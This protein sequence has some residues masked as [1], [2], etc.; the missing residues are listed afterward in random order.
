MGVRHHEE[1]HREL[2]PLALVDGGRPG[3]VDV[4]GVLGRVDDLVSGVL[5]ADGSH[6]LLLAALHLADP[7]DL[8]DLAV[9]DL[10]LV[11]IPHLHHPVPHGEEPVAQA[12]GAPILGRGIERGLQ[13]LVELGDA[14][15]AL[16]HAGEDLHVAGDVDPPLRKVAGDHS[17]KV[18]GDPVRPVCV[19][20][21]EPV[22]GLGRDRRQS[23]RV[24]VVRGGHDAVAVL[25]AV[26][27]GEAADGH[28]SR[29][30]QVAQ[31]L[32]GPD[33]REL[34]HV[35][36]DRDRGARSHRLEEGGGEPG[37]HHRELVDDQV[38]LLQGA[39]LV[40]REAAR[41]RLP[42]KHAVE[43]RGLGARDVRR[44]LGRTARR[45]R[46]RD[47]PLDRLEGL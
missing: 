5:D 42:F 38:V 46:D 32:P 2:A 1:H 35:A 31:D 33:G 41:G 45:T 3:V 26:D 25:L 8:P 19:G 22:G 39:A 15:L 43:R 14:D 37:V 29:R 9:V 6:H 36:D 20:E 24:D 47:L 13:D 34:V 7:A 18:L 44:A 10:L 21:G 17:D 27:D 16:T 23:A 30:D 28:A 4:V 12:D 40:A 11:V